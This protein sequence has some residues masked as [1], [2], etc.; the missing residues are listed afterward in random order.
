MAKQSHL[1]LDIEHF[2]KQSHN[3][4][5]LLFLFGMHVV[6]EQLANERYRKVALA[7]GYTPSL[8][9]IGRPRTL[10]TVNDSER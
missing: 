1:F 8:A 10:F 6:L 9:P 7:T 3:V 2:K 4:Y 5:R